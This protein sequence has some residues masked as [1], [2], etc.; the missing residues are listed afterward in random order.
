[1]ARE[2]AEADVFDR[3]NFLLYEREM[4]VTR[5]KALGSPLMEVI[6]G[7]S[8]AAMIW[9]GGY[10]VLR[11]ES[12]AGTFFAFMAAIVSIYRP[13]KKL[14]QA[15]SSIQQGMAGAIR[16]FAVLDQQAA[17]PECA[18]PVALP[19]SQHRVSIR[20][21]NFAYGER[22]ILK[23]IDLDIHP[24]EVVHLM[25]PNGAGKSTL[26][27]LIPRLY[28]ANS[29][30][31][32]LDGINIHELSLGSL[33]S[34][35][36]FVTQEPFLFDDTV[37]NNIAFGKAD[38]NEEEIV[39]AARRAHADEF[40]G[41]L[42]KGYDTNVG[43]LGRQLSGG[44]RQRLCIARAFVKDAP[45][46]ILDEPTS[47]LDKSSAELL[48]DAITALM[49]GRTVLIISHRTP[50]WMRADRVLWLEDGILSEKHDHDLTSSPKI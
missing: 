2:D 24:G 33:R 13:I 10:R 19:R 32:C 12:S 31:I 50:E 30:E 23:N 4:K 17:I 41:H 46:L 47:S 28:D 18:T 44:E 8:I 35:I 15:Y 37:R 26:A 42:P 29:G 21:L 49:E 3:K 1:F 40:I 27:H 11:M 6:G 7:L 34:R 36:S 38:A 20:R 16:V 45:I 14:I 22:E 25:G 48:R 39:S 43:E 5:Y 9:Y